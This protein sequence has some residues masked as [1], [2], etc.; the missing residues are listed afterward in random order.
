[1]KHKKTNWR[2]N[3]NKQL[4]LYLF[5]LGTIFYM[6]AFQILHFLS[7]SLFFWNNLLNC[8]KIILFLMSHYVFLF[9]PWKQNEILC[10][11]M[12]VINVEIVVWEQL[13]WPVMLWNTSF[14][15]LICNQVKDFIFLSHST[16]FLDHSGP[17]FI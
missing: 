4:I 3:S 7:N 15:P 10:I 16:V 9:S 14:F 2:V 1:M 11:N 6:T 8:V 13:S 5:N 17:L 12:L